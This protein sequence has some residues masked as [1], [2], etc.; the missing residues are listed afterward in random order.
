MAQDEHGLI[1]SNARKLTCKAWSSLCRI[2]GLG[3]GLEKRKMA[4][5]PSEIRVTMYKDFFISKYYVPHQKGGR[6]V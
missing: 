1:Y 2:M 5:A 4:W 3:K 6:E